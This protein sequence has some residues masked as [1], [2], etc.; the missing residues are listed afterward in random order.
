MKHCPHH[1]ADLNLPPGDIEVFLTWATNHD[2]Q[3][4]VRDPV[5]QSVYDDEPA[6]TSGGLLAS[7]GNVN[8]T[9]SEGDA[10]SYI[11]WPLGLARPG[12]YETEVWFQNSCDDTNIVEFSLTIVVND[13]VVAV[14]RRI[15][16]IGDRFVISFTIG[17]DGTA[18]A[19]PGGFISAG[20]APLDLVNEIASPIQSGTPVNASITQDNAFDVYAFSGQANQTVTIFMQT[21]SQTLDTSIYLVDQN[22]IL[23]TSNDDADENL[24]TGADQRPTD[25]LISNFTLP[26]TG[27]YRIIA[28]RFGTVFG[29]TVGT[30]RLTLQSN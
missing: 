25:S 28:T 10:V 18:N 8:C 30:Y 15:P 24:I 3:L 13:E 16:S 6:V 21:T 11:Y 22:G 26:A 7:Q 12:T 5:G 19:G 9:V 14:E 4:L 1:V 2:L 29:G 20:I 23:L 17:S 27:E